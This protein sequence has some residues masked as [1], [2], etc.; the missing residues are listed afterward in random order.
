MIAL[1]RVRYDLSFIHCEASEYI[2]WRNLA[3]RIHSSSVNDVDI[4]FPLCVRSL[5]E[6]RLL[7]HLLGQEFMQETDKLQ[8]LS[9][10]IGDETASFRCGMQQDTENCFAR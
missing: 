7:E 3:L 10:V 1:V 9:E 5:G 2:F 8:V 4:T 6:A